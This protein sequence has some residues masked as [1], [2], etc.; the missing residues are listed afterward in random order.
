MTRYQWPPD[1]SNLAFKRQYS[2]RLLGHVGKLFAAVE[3]RTGKVDG[4]TFDR[5]RQTEF[6]AFLEYIHKNIPASVNTIQIVLGN[7]WMRKQA[8]P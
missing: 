5:K 2:D 3:T 1:Y 4:Q 8:G 7:L 6:I